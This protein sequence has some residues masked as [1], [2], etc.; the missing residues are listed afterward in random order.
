MSIINRVLVTAL[1][2]L[3][4]S[5]AQADDSGWVSGYKAFNQFLLK[6]NGN[7]LPVKIECRDSNKRDYT[8]GNAEY[9]VTYIEADP[10]PFYRWG[11]GSGFAE[12]KALAQSEGLR[13][14]SSGSFTRAKSGL[15][16]RCGIWHQ[17]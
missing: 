3:L 12:A 5:A 13:L 17:S 1:G 11:V 2:V 4:C 8:E 15:V 9:R 7:F 10:R 6:R 16:V 14:V